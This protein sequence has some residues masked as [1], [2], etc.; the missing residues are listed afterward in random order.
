MDALEALYAQRRATERPEPPRLAAVNELAALARAPRPD[1]P[2]RPIPP[3]SERIESVLPESA[4]RRIEPEVVPE[5]DDFK[6]EGLRRK[7]VAGVIGVAAAV[8]VASIVALLLVN[9]FPKDKDADQ[10][11]TA[12]MPPPQ[13]SQADAV[14]KPLASPIPASVVASDGDQ[15]INHEQSER[16][17]QQFMQWGQKAAPTDKP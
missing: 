8:A 14:S 10:S 3:L 1:T 2:L 6:S 12:A 11:V 4:R 7:L 5:P 17:L 13:S 16:L 15:N 9:I